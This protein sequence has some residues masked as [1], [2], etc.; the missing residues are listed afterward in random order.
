[1]VGLEKENLFLIDHLNEEEDIKKYKEKK[2]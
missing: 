2:F 1:M